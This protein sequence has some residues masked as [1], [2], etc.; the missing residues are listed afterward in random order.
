VSRTMKLS[1]IGVLL[2]GSPAAIGQ[3]TLGPLLDA[4]ARKLTVE[5]FKA[6]LVQRSLVGPTG[7]G[8]EFE[9]MYTSGGTIIGVSDNPSN[10]FG[11]GSL[12]GEWRIDAEGRI[13][14]SMRMGRTAHTMAPRCQFWFKLGDTYYVADSDSDRYAKVLPRKV[15]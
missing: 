1:L 9:V 7:I 11:P 2:F 8:V 10:R 15:K 14:S 13:C 5:E 3:S 4:G 12:D 6:E